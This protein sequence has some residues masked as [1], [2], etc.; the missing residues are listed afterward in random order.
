MSVPIIVPQMPIQ[1]VFGIVAKTLSFTDFYGSTG[2]YVSTYNLLGSNV[3]GILKVTAPD[4]TVI[5]NN[6]SYS[7]PDIVGSTSTWLKSIPMPVNGDGSLVTGIYQVQ[8]SVQITDGTNPPYIVVNNFSYNFQYATPKVSITQSADCISPLYKTAD[9][10][11]YTVNGVLPTMTRTLT[12]NYPDGSAG[13]SS[14]IVTTGN[15]ISTGVFYNGT[16]TTT[17]STVATYIY[18]AVGSYPTFTV[19]DTIAGAQELL[20]DC[21]FVCAISCCLQTLESNM[22]KAQ[23]V[24]D[25]LYQAYKDQFELCMSYVELALLAISCGQSTKVNGYITKIQNIANCSSGCDCGSGSYSLVVGLGGSSVNVSVVSGGSP[26]SVTSSV[27]GNTTVYTISLSSTFV[28]IVNNSYNTVVNNTDGT[29]T[30]T[31]SGSNPK[32]YTVNSTNAVP[33]RVE[34]KCTMQCNSP[35]ANAASWTI[36][37]ASVVTSGTKF[38]APTVA[39]YTPS[40]PNWLNINNW[41]SVSGFFTGTPDNNYKILL[42]YSQESIGLFIGLLPSYIPIQVFARDVTAGTFIF[43][44]FSM[45]SGNIVI[46]TNNSFGNFKGELTIVIS[47]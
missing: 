11:N 18:T 6:T 19:S 12:L 31:S 2:V 3:K 5:Y 32:T 38:Q 26:V 4:G 21:T 10:T 8:Y 39:V 7:T 46:P 47:E 42:N 29:L 13:A 16:Q 28:N 35:V 44:F 9:L 17:V 1:T 25:I 33:N 23:G 34:L 43:D 37:N 15:I 22:S 41:F 27:V 36:T 20:V 14:P 24:D 30:V 45:V 40:D